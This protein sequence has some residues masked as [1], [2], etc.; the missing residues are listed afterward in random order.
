MKKSILALV[1][2]CAAM[3]ALP[4]V[5]SAGVWHLEPENGE[6]SQG[7]TVAAGGTAKLLT[8]NSSD[9]VTS[10]IDC[11]SVDGSG[12]YETTT[13]G[14]LNLVFHGCTTT[15]P[16]FGKVNCTTS[17]KTT[18]TIE[19][20]TLPFHNVLIHAGTPGVLITPAADGTFAHFS[21][22]GVAVTV[23]GNGIIG[24]VTAECGDTGVSAAELDFEAVNNTQKFKQVTTE[25]TVYDLKRN[26]GETATQT[27][28]GTVENEFPSK[29]V[30]T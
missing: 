20:T 3:F 18:G 26:N 21:C 30:C 8:V 27:G 6:P 14:T 2:V 24:D 15:I 5:A 12:E 13:T 11:T 17:G 19:T 29:V 25:G 1:A 7:F 28:N 10:E 9:A 4:A 22:F 16:I 23:E